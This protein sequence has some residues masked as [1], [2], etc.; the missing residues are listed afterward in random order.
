MIGNRFSRG[1]AARFHDWSHRYIGNPLLSGTLR[2]LVP[3][4]DPRCP[5]RI[6]SQLGPAYVAMDLRTTGF[7]FSPEMVIKAVRHGLKMTELPVPTLPDERDRPAHLRTVPDGWRHLSFILMCS[8]NWLFIAPGLALL[9]LGIADVTLLAI[10]P[11]RSARSC[12]TLE[13]NCLEWY[14]P[15][16]ASRSQVSAYSPGY[17]AIP[18]HSIPGPG[19]SSELFVRQPRTGLDGQWRPRRRRIGRNPVD[20]HHVGLAGI[21]ESSRPP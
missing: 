3:S 2:L 14:S 8:P 1:P 4:E 5:G 18:S 10:G 7:E 11:I 6:S 17:L 9:V 12:L 19:S 15:F 13:P 21:W 16:S 20:F